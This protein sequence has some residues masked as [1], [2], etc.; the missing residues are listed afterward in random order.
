MQYQGLA[1]LGD[2]IDGLFYAVLVNGKVRLFIERLKNNAA[3]MTYEFAA[4]V[5]TLGWRKNGTPITNLAVRLIGL[6]D[7][8]A[9]P[10]DHD[11]GIRKQ[12]CRKL[13]PN[14]RV[15]SSAVIRM[16]AWDESSGKKGD[17]GN[18]HKALQRAIPTEWVAVAMDDGTAREIRRVV[19]QHPTRHW[20]EC[21]LL[22]PPPKP[23]GKPLPP[24]PRD[25]KDGEGNVVEFPTKPL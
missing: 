20:I 13:K 14:E 8:G 22:P 16:M 12:V 23:R 5:I 25:G 9:S 17:G 1:A 18:Q 6:A 21:R 4:S 11:A 19:E 10:V 7:Q 15:S 24:D 3:G 2:L